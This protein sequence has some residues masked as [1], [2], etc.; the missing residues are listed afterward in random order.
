MYKQLLSIVLDSCLGASLI[1][2][3]WDKQWELQGWDWTSHRD[4]SQTLSSNLHPL[5]MLRSHIC[6]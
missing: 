4:I 1:S 5:S 3:S 2:E 6:V